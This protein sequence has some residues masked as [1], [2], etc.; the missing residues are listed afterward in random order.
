MGA[1]NAR[2][3]GTLAIHRGALGDLLGAVPSLRALRAAF[4]AGPMT[5]LAN[6]AAGGLL[7]RCGLV[8]EA[9]DVNAAEWLPLFADDTLP[10]SLRQWCA[11]Y[12]RAIAWVH[13]PDGT[14]EPT[15]HAAGVARVVVAPPFGPRGGRPHAEHL[16]RALRAIDLYPS[17]P[18]PPLTLHPADAAAGERWLAER[19]PPDARPVL[20]LHPGSGSPKKNWPADAFQQVARTVRERGAAH[21]VVLL[22]PA[23]TDGGVANDAWNGV[24]DAVGCN[25]PL[26]LLAGIV[27]H[28]GAWLGNDSGTTHLAAALGVPTVALFGAASDPPVWTPRG[29]HVTVLPVAC[30][31]GARA[32]ASDI[33]AVL[34]AVGMPAGHPAGILAASRR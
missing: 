6:P 1:V 23:E 14:L 34:A 33:R 9:R 18:G 15:L 25:L 13:D 11:G 19:L 4:P 7:Q 28:C 31:P 21:V 27:S 26:P 20:A 22:G 30:G 10:E 12:A 17:I 29:A 5:L 3:R 32:D 8:D 24:S 2:A 16:A